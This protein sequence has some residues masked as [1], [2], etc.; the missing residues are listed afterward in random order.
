MEEETNYPP[1]KPVLTPKDEI[2]LH[3]RLCDLERSE[4]EERPRKPKDC[5]ATCQ[6]CK[7]SSTMA[8]HYCAADGPA[9]GR[10]SIDAIYQE[11][12][13]NCRKR[14]KD[15]QRPLN[16][17]MVKGRPSIDEIGPIAVDTDPVLERL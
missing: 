16:P 11:H 12:V 3:V 8:T 10:M 15:A 2:R 9:K 14:P 7:W 17:H 6:N 4:K 1:M 5:C 13:Q